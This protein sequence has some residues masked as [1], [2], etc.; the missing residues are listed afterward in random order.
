[1]Y[2]QV[3]DFARL[4]ALPLVDACELL[5]HVQMSMGPSEAFGGT[6][7][8]QARTPPEVNGAASNFISIFIFYKLIFFKFLFIFTFY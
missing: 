8:P 4:L 6:T 2:L 3:S 7:G 5:L 1:L